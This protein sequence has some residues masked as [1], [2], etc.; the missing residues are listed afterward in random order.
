MS[1]RYA[2]LCSDGSDSESNPPSPAAKPVQQVAPVQKVPVMELSYTAPV[3][4]FGDFCA[5]PKK[6]AHN[7]KAS[8]LKNQ[9]KG[10]KQ[11]L[12]Q[13]VM[14]EYVNTEQQQKAP[15][16]Q[17]QQQKQEYVNGTP[18]AK[19][20]QQLTQQ[21][22]ADK[23]NQKKK[24]RATGA[25]NYFALLHDDDGE[26]DDAADDDDDNDFSPI[27]KVQAV[28]PKQLG[29]I[30][31]N[32]QPSF[33]AVLHVETSVKPNRDRVE[34]LKRPFKTEIIALNLSFLNSKSKKIEFEFQRYVRPIN[35]PLN[36]ETSDLTGITQ[37][38]MDE[39]NAQPLDEVFRELDRFLKEKSLVSIHRN[40]KR[41]SASISG[42]EHEFLIVT[43]CDLNG[44]LSTE[45]ARKGLTP[46]Q[47]LK[48]YFEIR[49]AFCENYNVQASNLAEMLQSICMEFVGVPHQDESKNVARVLTTMLQD[50]PSKIEVNQTLK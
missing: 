38:K 44:L 22:P 50:C 19:V 4:D 13:S 20:P 31:A 10:E 37:Q 18:T 25:N 11:N 40:K 26:N 42:L 45:I 14:T 34:E 21:S 12:V 16:Q 35:F 2:A 36:K 8:N 29:L 15:V 24:T 39:T 27:E 47:F 3:E 6:K 1:S 41:A 23:K 49:K 46:P 48:K 17:Q 28:L 33:Y 5:V 30:K 9:T 7:M 32:N 43:D